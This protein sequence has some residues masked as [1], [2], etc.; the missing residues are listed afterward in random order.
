[1]EKPTFH[2]I[3]TEIYV[4]RGEE[5]PVKTLRVVG[6]SF[7]LS[8]LAKEVAEILTRHYGAE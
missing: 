8:G 3:D 2:A 7:S 6:G 1:M 5:R 4:Q